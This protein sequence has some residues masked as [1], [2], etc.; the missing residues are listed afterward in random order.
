V[1]IPS[2]T[3]T[4]DNSLPVCAAVYLEALEHGLHFLLLKVVIE[5]LRTY[6]I[7]IAKLVLKVW[8]SI[9]S[10]IALASLNAL[11]AA[12]WPLLISTSFNET[13][14]PVVVRLAS[15]HRLPR[16]PFSVDKPS[17]IHG[18]T[19]RFIY[20]KKVTGDWTIPTCNKCGPN[21]T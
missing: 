11:S 3:D 14:R 17:S 4:V 6:D 9:L 19:Y 2:P 18:W 8:A 21:K 16:L 15:N 12:P 13:A 10:I 20:V 7:V 1:V 5:I